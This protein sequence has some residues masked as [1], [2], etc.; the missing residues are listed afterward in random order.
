MKKTQVRV[1]FSL[2]GDEFPI[3]EVTDRLGIT[4]TLTYK[5]GELINR[6]NDYTRDFPLYRKETVW[7]LDTNYQDSYDVKEQMDQILIPLKNKTVIINQLKVDYKLECKISIVIIMENGD[8]PGLYLDNEQIEFAN[9]VKAEFDIDLY[10]NPYEDDI[11][12]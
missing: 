11:N 4:P 1:Y 5:K 8:T 12:D 10:A 7:D 2:F 9:S 6:S 3:D